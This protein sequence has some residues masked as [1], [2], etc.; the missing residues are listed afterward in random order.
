MRLPRWSEIV[1][2]PLEVLETRLDQSLFVAG[3]PGS[4]KT[5]LAIQRARMLV[6]SG[7]RVLMITFNRMLRR[8]IALLEDTGDIE[9]GTMHSYVGRDFTR[10]TDA[11]IPTPPGRSYDW[12]WAQAMA[13]LEG[14]PKAGPRHDHLIVDEAQDLPVGLFTYARRHLAPQLSVFADENQAVTPRCSTLVQIKRAASLPDPLV[15]QDNHRNTPEIMAVA[16]H[17]HAGALPA[18]R[19]RRG[20]ADLPQLI[21]H[22]SLQ[23]SCEMIARWFATTRAS[24]GVVVDQNSTGQALRDMLEPRVQG[25]VDIYTSNQSNEES[26]HIFEPGITILNY[27]SVKGQEFHTL[28]VLELERFMPCASAHDRRI[29]YMICSRP[30]EY[31]FMVSVSGQL[32]SR[33]LASLP[34]HDLLERP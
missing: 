9:V 28:F 33:A 16:E 2:V 10:R 30:R 11:L 3:P 21:Q 22:G 29:M 12:Q 19:R 34:A 31:L 20:S 5:A 17:F 1:G 14:H 18:L 32:S 25:R 27:R 23:Q 4:G 26:I 8:A 15:L 13:M 7:Q 24:I 6:D